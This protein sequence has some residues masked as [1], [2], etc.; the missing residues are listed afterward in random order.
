MPIYWGPNCWLC[1]YFIFSLAL[2]FLGAL[3]PLLYSGGETDADKWQAVYDFHQLEAA[4]EHNDMGYLD[5]DGTP[6]SEGL[7]GRIE[8][9]I[10]AGELNG[11]DSY[12]NQVEIKFTDEAG[13]TI[14]TQIFEYAPP[15]NLDIA[16]P[17]NLDNAAPENLD[18]AAP[19]NLDK[20]APENLDKA[21]PDNLEDNVDAETFNEK[22]IQNNFEEVMKATDADYNGNADNHEGNIEWKHK[23]MEIEFEQENIQNDSKHVSTETI[24]FTD[25]RFGFETWEDGTTKDNVPRTMKYFATHNNDT[26]NA[27]SEVENPTEYDVEI[28]K[29]SKYEQLLEDQR[30]EMN[31][32]GEMVKH[33]EIKINGDFNYAGTSLGALMTAGGIAYKLK[34]GRRRLVVL[35]NLLQTIN[36]KNQ[37]S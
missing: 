11:G 3:A 8:A 29:I 7:R 30:Y 15:E 4:Y 14:D 21:A 1:C 26:G 27:L 23:E 34:H 13:K 37:R 12:Q 28:K 9:D 10:E 22:Y 16:A 36:F 35:E 25:K 17:E 31:A 6:L 19:E 20:A 18:K 24:D 33:K 32:E 5:G 2:L